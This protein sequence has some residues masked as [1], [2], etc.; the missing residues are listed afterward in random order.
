MTLII[1]GSGVLGQIV[2]PTFRA[3]GTR[4][5][6]AANY[7]EPFPSDDTVLKAD[8]T[9]EIEVQRVVNDVVEQAGHI[10][11]LINLASWTWNGCA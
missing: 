2:V 10:D 4:V 8:A 1:G 7:P 5:F 3:E 6:V 11:G 9:N